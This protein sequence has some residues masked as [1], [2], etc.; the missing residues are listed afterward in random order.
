[1]SENLPARQVRA[2]DQERAAAVERLSV[3]YQ[4]G[5]LDLAEFTERMERAWSAVHVTDLDVLLA[6]LPATTDRPLPALRPMG[7]DLERSRVV[8]G[9]GLPVTFALMSGASRAGEWTAAGTH[10]AVAIMGGWS[11]TCA[12]P[13]SP[14]RRPRCWP[15]PS[16]VGST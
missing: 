4:E 15:S 9:T 7:S 2:G 16:W 5:M 6:D 10:T 3:G 12:R 14:S 8:G 1:M 13:A 11:W